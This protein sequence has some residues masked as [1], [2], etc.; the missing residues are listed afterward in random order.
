MRPVS[1]RGSPLPSIW[2][3]PDERA[4]VWQSPRRAKPLPLLPLALAPS[5][6]LPTPTHSS[7]T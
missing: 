4:N 5:S 1:S 7:S 2:S 6:S 3:W